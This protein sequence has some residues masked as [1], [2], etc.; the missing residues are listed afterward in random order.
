[1]AGKSVERARRAP[2]GQTLDLERY[3]PALITFIANKLTHGSSSLYRKHFGVGVIEWRCMALLAIEPWISPGRFSQ[4]IGLDKAA[5]SRLIRALQDLGLAEVRANSQ[6]SRF[7]EIAL[8]EKGRALH[9]RIIQLAFERERRLLAD[10]TPAERETLIAALNKMH[11]RIAQV[12]APIDLV[13][14]E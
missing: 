4:V 2:E 11:R 12:N 14:T 7:L 5:V 9:D 6:R 1:M 8:T 3:V 10:L 13:A